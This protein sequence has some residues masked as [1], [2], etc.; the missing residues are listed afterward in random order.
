MESG[1]PFWGDDCVRVTARRQ[2]S[3]LI[4]REP[5]PGRRRDRHGR[6]PRGPLIFPALPAWLTRK[7]QFRREV[8]IALGE[9]V[10]RE[11]AVDTIEFG[12]EDVPPSDP[13]EW[14][15]HDVTM[16]RVFPRDRRRGLT[17]RIV[18]YR[19]PLTERST[20]E[21]LGSVIRL[22]LAQRISEVLTVSP[23]ELL[24]Y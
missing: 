11:P 6:G 15:N 18:L 4:W 20:P 5:M 13:A 14:E 17:D 22:V 9:L 3:N 16:A 23:Q 12:V 8:E 21:S 10:A 7:E 1:S 19:R 24:G 2:N